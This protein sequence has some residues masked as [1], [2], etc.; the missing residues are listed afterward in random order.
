VIT[1]RTISEAA[2][3]FAGTLVKISQRSEGVLNQLGAAVGYDK[4]GSP[5]GA[6]EAPGVSSRIPR[7]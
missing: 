2:D 3:L 5:Q 7:Q 1:V 4:S 6:A